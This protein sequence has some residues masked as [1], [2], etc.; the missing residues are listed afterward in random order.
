MGNLGVLKGLCQITRAGTNNVWENVGGKILYN[1]QKGLS[2][3]EQ[4][5]ARR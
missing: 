1:A 2:C 5:H 3:T 4:P